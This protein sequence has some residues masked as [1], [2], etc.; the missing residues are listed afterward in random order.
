MPPRVEVRP[1]LPLGSYARRAAGPGPF[2]LAEPGCRLFA[3]ARHGLWHGVRSAGLAP[4]D[5]VLVPAWHHGSEVEALLRAGLG[6]RFYECAE[7]LEP[8]A[9]QLD[10]LR[11]PQV[12]AL[13]LIHYLGFPQDGPR[14]RSWC[15]ERG[16]LLLE[17]AAPSW[18]S[19]YDGRPVGSFGDLAIFSLHKMLGVPDGG[20]LVSSSR[21]PHPRG[22]LTLEA[23]ELAKRHRASLGQRWGPLARLGSR[24]RRPRRSPP[25][26]DFALGD[27]DRPASAVTRLLAPRLAGP[28]VVTRRRSNYARLLAD[29]GDLVPAP[30]DRLPAGACPEVF[31]VVSDDKPALLDRLARRGVLAENLWWVPHPS[32]PVERFPRTAARRASILSLPVHQELGSG[33]LEQIVSAVRAET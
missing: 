6:C 14:W 7:S 1:P 19:S 15:D 5:E 8:D 18:L 29:L 33:H 23:A 25:A 4:G 28:R 20:A 3:M 26:S 21:P 2:P 27:P 12:R 24:R 22:S 16:L 11:G 32:L 9:A 13:H 10:A 17:D 31:P 30:F